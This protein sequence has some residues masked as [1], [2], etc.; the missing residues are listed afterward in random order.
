[1][2]TPLIDRKPNDIAEIHSY[3]AHIYYEIGRTRADAELLRS[4]IAER[5]L[6]QLGAWHDELVGPHSRS[7]YQVAFTPDLFPSFTPWLMLNR[8]GLAVLVHPN[9][10]SPYEDH[11]AHALWL[12]E[13]LP[14]RLD[15]LPKSIHAIGESH[16]AI[17]PNTAPHLN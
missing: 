8:Q 13:I 2:N 10:D 11:S 16:R 5:F 3:H 17:V 1:M 15:D 12:G 9:T 6:A 4:W 7:M 14:V